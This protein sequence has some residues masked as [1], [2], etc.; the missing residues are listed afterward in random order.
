MPRN[1]LLMAG[2]VVILALTITTDTKSQSQVPNT[3]QVS[4]QQS[5]SPQVVIPDGRGNARVAG[6]TNLFCAGYIK[7]QR[8]VS[9]PE[10]VGAESEPEQRT[11]AE[12]DVAVSY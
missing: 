2:C 12:G 6:R 8:F 3:N 10:I 5:V 7:Y 1:P 4:V 11:F 9:S